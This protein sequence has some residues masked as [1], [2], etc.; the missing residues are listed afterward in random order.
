ML[1]YEVVFINLYIHEYGS[2]KYLREKKAVFIGNVSNIERERKFSFQYEIA[3]LG[4]K[5]A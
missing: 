4:A 1:R 2:S 3:E 5:E